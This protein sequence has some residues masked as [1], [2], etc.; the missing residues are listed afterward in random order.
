MELARRNLF[1]RRGVKHIVDAHQRIMN[2]IVIAH[3]ADVKFE[4]IVPK[5]EAHVLLFFFIA[6]EHANL[7]DIRSQKRLDDRVAERP[8]TP[9]YE[10]YLAHEHL[11]LFPYDSEN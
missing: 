1:E 4:P 6:A 8:R 7:A 9:G 3:V 2:T 5:L 10:Q 11:N